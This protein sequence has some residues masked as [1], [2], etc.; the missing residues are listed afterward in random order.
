MSCEH[1]FVLT[2]QE[3]F[4]PYKD[5]GIA[6]DRQVLYGTAYCEKCCAV[7]E[8]ILAH[9]R[10]GSLQGSPAC[11]IMHKG[12]SRDASASLVPEPSAEVAAS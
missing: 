7:L 12:L 9:Y 1:K 11:R 2:G 4:L 10:L 6:L 5:G 8:L 3:Y